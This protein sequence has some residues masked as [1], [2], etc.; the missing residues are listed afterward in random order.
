[1]GDVP[2]RTS[3][4]PDDPVHFSL[5]E[6]RAEIELKFKT[7]EGAIQVVSVVLPNVDLDPLNNKLREQMAAYAEIDP[8]TPDIRG[9][10]EAID[11]A[12]LQIERDLAAVDLAV[13]TEEFRLLFREAT[14]PPLFLV[15][16]ARLLASHDLGTGVR[17]D[18]FEYV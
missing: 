2:E 13:P 11:N 3:V 10:V 4:A 14:I 18:R 7:V 5:A 9:K 1:D 17:R 6:L 12:I 15:R 16:Y 8:E